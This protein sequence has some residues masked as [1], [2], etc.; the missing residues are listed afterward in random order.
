LGNQADIGLVVLLPVERY[1]IEFQEVFHGILQTLN[2]AFQSFI[3]EWAA[4]IS[5]I[6]ADVPALTVMADLLRCGA[7]RMG[8]AV[9]A[10]QQCRREQA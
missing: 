10:K 8:R 9:E 3:T 4:L 1:T 5:N 7:L 6:V 2:V